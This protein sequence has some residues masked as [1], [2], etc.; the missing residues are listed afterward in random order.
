MTI[1][2]TKEAFE[3]QGKAREF[4]IKAHG[5]QLYGKQPYIHYLDMVSSTL[6]STGYRR[7]L[8]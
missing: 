7:M 3:L 1:K 4:A 8:R 6:H 5:D 2:H